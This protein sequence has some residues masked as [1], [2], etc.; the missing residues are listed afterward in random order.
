MNE[1]RGPADMYGAYL[2]PPV[3]KKADYSVIFIHNEG[4]SDMCGHGIIALGK[5]LVELGFVPRR[6]PLTPVGFNTPAGFVQV[7]VEWDGRHAGAVCF[8]NVP[9]FIYARDVRVPTP[10]FG[11]LQGDIVFGGAFYYYI[12]VAQT[13]LE[14][15]SGELRALIEL[16][17][18]AKAAAVAQVSIVH[19]LEPGLDTLYGVIIDGPPNGA[20]ADQSNVCIFADREVD[21]SPTGTGTS[22]RAAQLYL[23]GKLA[24]N[25]PFINS[26]IVGS[27]LTARVLERTTV[28]T[29]EA[30]ITE[31]SGHAHIMGMQQWLLER[32]DP[33]PQGFF[34]R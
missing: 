17:A 28:G 15:R 23:R 33:F 9:A 3:T 24:L 5:V 16:G 4:Y 22:G 30:A 20:G 12:D 31:V 32:D 7:Q 14:V 34:L 25:T 29:L 6:T 1:P 11:T 18:Q 19:P 8:R 26:S 10:D 27:R 21:R 13:G 2:L